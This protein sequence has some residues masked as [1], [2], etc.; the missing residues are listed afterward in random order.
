M[1]TMDQAP[2]ASDPAAREESGGANRPGR[3]RSLWQSPWPYVVAVVALFGAIA[4]IVVLAIPGAGSTPPSTAFADQTLGPTSGPAEA[5]L[6]LTVDSV[7]PSAGSLKLR[8]QASP[9]DATPPGGVTV[10]TDSG[11]IPVLVIRPNQLDSERNA[12]VPFTAGDVSSYPFDRYAADIG[13]IAVKGTDTSL[14]GLERR[15][16]VP[17]EVK[18][19]STASSMVVSGSASVQRPTKETPLPLAVLDLHMTRTNAAQGWVLAMMAIYWAVAILVAMVTILVVTGRRPWETRLLAWYSAVMF[20]L[21]TFR[22]AAPNVP[23]VGTFFDYYAVLDSVGV[24]A[25]SLVALMVFY[26]TQGSKRLGL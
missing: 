16:P 4:A 3:R 25:L 23:P 11:A 15:T 19:V 7:D 18:G 10:F 14:A 17:V 9:T 5:I 26:L 2:K 20:A 21:I 1:A 13:M 6:L 8:V 24:V 22:V 12:T